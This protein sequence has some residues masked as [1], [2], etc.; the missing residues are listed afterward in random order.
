MS[1]FRWRM[2]PP[3]NESKFPR[4]WHL[5]GNDESGKTVL[6]GSVCGEYVE[7][8]AP[9]GEGY[10]SWRWRLPSGRISAIQY[11]EEA[12]AKA[13]LEQYLRRRAVATAPASA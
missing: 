3:T 11:A 10:V 13:A 6:L 7:V 4:G 9:D 5:M 12:D 2:A 8:S 1:R